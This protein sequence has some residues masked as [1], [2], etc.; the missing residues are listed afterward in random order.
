MTSDAD[1]SAATPAT[2][3]SLERESSATPASEFVVSQSADS[4]V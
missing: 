3:A 2:N 1:R 4:D